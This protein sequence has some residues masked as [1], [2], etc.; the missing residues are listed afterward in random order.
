M[1]S[2][3]TILVY[4]VAILLQLVSVVGVVVGWAFMLL[5]TAFLVAWIVDHNKNTSFTNQLIEF[6]LSFKPKRKSLDT[7]PLCGPEREEDLPENHCYCYLC[8]KG[9]H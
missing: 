6:V 2:I 1:V 4:L 7:C 3:G 5:V 8:G 9:L